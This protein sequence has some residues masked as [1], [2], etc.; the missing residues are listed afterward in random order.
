MKKS[1]R[2]T[3]A[4]L[5]K[6]PKISDRKAADLIGVSQPTVTRQRHK[7]Q[8]AGLLTFSA[9]PDLAR[10]GYSIIAFT[11]LSDFQILP[12]LKKEDSVIFLAKQPSRLFV[13]SVHKGIEEYEMFEAKYPKIINAMH[14]VTP[15][16]E[17]AKALTFSQ[18]IK[19][20]K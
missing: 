3:L 12:S 16:A 18:L 2:K 19:P 4:C 5:L 13:I 10:L 9:Y 11:E 1:V 20:D 14:V 15:L 17:T 8:E 6:N 7:L